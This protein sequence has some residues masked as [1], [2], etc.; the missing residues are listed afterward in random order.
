MKTRSMKAFLPLGIFAI[1]IIGFYVGTRLNPQQLS[2]ELIGE[3]VPAFELPP[4]T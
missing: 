2:S 3:P 1:L 4:R